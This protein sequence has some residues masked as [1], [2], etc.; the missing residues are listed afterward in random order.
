MSSRRI[1]FSHENPRL[2]T[3]YFDFRRSNFFKDYNFKFYVL[4]GLQN[5][6]LSRIEEVEN[7]E[8]NKN[9][10]SRKNVLFVS[11]IY[12]NMHLS[13]VKIYMSKITHVHTH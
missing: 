11:M 5:V 4:N 3:V 10:M 13:A 2:E 9:E 1:R 12:Y 7:Q 6:K 8:K